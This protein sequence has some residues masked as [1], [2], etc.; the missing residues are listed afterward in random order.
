M[1]T[2]TLREEDGQTV[3]SWGRKTKSFPTEEKALA[4][5]NE[6]RDTSDRVVRVDEDGY[7]SPVTRR[8]WRS[9]V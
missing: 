5:V 6:R 7:R 8:R 3:V 9:R 1:T 2:W 4:F